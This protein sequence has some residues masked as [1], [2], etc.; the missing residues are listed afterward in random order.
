VAF[1]TSVGTLKYR[2]AALTWPRRNWSDQPRTTRRSVRVTGVFFPASASGVGSG[3]GVSRGAGGV[4]GASPVC[5]PGV[6][7]VK[8]S[9]SALPHAATKSASAASA[10]GGRNLNVMPQAFHSGH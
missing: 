8:R 3:A 10:I 1:K 9:G 4:T 7:S 2:A 5:A 6:R